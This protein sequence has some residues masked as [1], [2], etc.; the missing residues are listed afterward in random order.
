MRCFVFGGLGR[1]MGLGEVDKDPGARMG[2]VD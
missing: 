1:G 2:T